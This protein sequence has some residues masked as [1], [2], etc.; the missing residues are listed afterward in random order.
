MKNQRILIISGIFLLL[1]GFSN[2]ISAQNTLQA[3]LELSKG[4]KIKYVKPGRKAVIWYENQK[5]KIKIDSIGPD[6]IFTK[7]DSFRISNINKISVRFK[8]TQI[9]GSIIGTAGVVFI[10]L[11]A[12]LII[13][14]LRSNDLGGVFVVAIGI[15]ANIIGI[16]LT[17]VGSSFFFIGKKYKRAKGWNF[18][19]V[20]IE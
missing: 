2:L 10:G 4:N 7:T 12:G 14:G 20:Q 15:I 11:G 16:P 17:A 3:A 9:A 13:T 18:K 19:A 6:K 1:S 5:Y 8:G